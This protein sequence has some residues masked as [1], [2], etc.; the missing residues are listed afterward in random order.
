MRYSG[1]ALHPEAHQELPAVFVHRRLNVLALHTGSR[2]WTNE[3]LTFVVPGQVGEYYA[4]TERWAAYVDQAT[5]FGVGVYSPVSDQLVAYRI[6]PEGS[7]ARSDVSYMAPL[8]TARIQPNTEFSYDVYLAA[9]RVDEMRGWF[10]DI[11]GSMQAAADAAPYIRAVEPPPAD[12]AARVPSVRRDF[13]MDG[14]AARSEGRS[15]DGSVSFIGSLPTPAALVVDSHLASPT[16]TR[17]KVGQKPA[18]LKPKARRAPPLVKPWAASPGQPGGSSSTKDKGAANKG[19]SSSSS[20]KDKGTKGSKAAAAAPPKPPTKPPTKPPPKAPAPAV[21]GKEASKSPH[22][23]AVGV[24]AVGVAAATQPAATQPAAKRARTRHIAGASRSSRHDAAAAAA[25]HRSGPRDP[26]EPGGRP[27]ADVVI[28]TPSSAP[29]LAHASVHP[30]LLQGSAGLDLPHSSTSKQVAAAQATAA[31]AAT[32]TAAGA[33]Q[34]PKPAAEEREAVVHQQPVQDPEVVKRG[35]AVQPAAPELHQHQQPASQEAQ[36]SRAQASA[37]SRVQQQQQ[38][39]QEQEGDAFEAAASR[40]VAAARGRPQ[41]PQGRRSQHM[42][43]RVTVQ[44]TA[45]VQL[46][47]QQPQQ[48]GMQRHGHDHHH[49]RHQQQQARVE[50]ASARS[51]DEDA[52]EQ[53]RQQQRLAQLFS[54]FSTAATTLI[55]KA[56][57]SEAFAAASHATGGRNSSGTAAAAGSVDVASALAGASA[58]LSKAL[59]AGKWDWGQ[60]LSNVFQSLRSR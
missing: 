51:A 57:S 50:I 56:S 24:A 15:G 58:T 8:V 3:P 5:G 52:S 11:A 25:G 23:A 27:H 20:D 2:P 35:L 21:A 46:G 33:H 45:H 6:G 42:Q 48:H 60:V 16:P 22:A 18:D 26:S 55:N 40:A 54:A 10:A 19:S 12:A 36:Y 49:D 47:T 7:T 38:H 37:D 30:A 59:A 32:P 17:V 41:Y 43:P 13:L 31:A 44:Q 1:T 34:Q 9:G 4:P 28:L 53:Q 39:Q 29:K 14:T